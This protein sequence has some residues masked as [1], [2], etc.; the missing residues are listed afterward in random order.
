M[1]HDHN[2]D[3]M[4]KIGDEQGNETCFATIW[5]KEELKL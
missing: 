1:S 2:H 3:H 5:W 4:K